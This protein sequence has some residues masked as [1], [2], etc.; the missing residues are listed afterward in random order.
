MEQEWSDTAPRASAELPHGQ[1]NTGV[2]RAGRW[3][4]LGST[5]L[6]MKR[7]YGLS[8]L[9]TPSL[10]HCQVGWH[11]GDWAQSGRACAGG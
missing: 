3:Q 11:L 7:C 6:G 5:V 9:A 8:G 2:G 1:R 4:G 10:G